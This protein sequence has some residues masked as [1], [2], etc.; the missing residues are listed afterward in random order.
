MLTQTL[1]TLF[2]RDIDL[3]MKELDAYP[4]EAEIWKLGNGIKNCAG[5]LTL[6]L[7]GNL[8]H[9]IGAVLGQSG[10]VRNRD[11]EFSDKGVPREK[12]KNDLQQ[13]LTMIKEVI[14]RLTPTQM[15]SEYP[16]ELLGQKWSTTFFLV[17]LVSHFN[18][19]LG[20]VNYHRRLLTGQ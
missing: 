18:Y 5:N 12:M 19:H 8:N 7:I 13:T 3:L 9:F 6:H 2:Q 20:Q 14:P 4:S 16:L 17:H 15:E 11:L 1:V 10:Y